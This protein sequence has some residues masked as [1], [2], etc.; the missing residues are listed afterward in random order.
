MLLLFIILNKKIIRI[1]NRGIAMLRLAIF[2]I[3][4]LVSAL[5]SVSF[6]LDGEYPYISSEDYTT[7][8][9]QKWK[10]EIDS[11]PFYYDEETVY[12]FCYD[13]YPMYMMIHCNGMLIKK[14]TKD[15]EDCITEARLHYALSG[16]LNERFN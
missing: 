10:E 7:L 1:I 5:I 16:I 14:E 2:G 6:T 13:S 11:H 8:C 12:N 15:Y 9:N 3:I 4:F